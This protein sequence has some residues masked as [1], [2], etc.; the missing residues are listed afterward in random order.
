MQTERLDKK[1]V[2]GWSWY[3]KATAAEGDDVLR[4]LNAT[5]QCRFFSNPLR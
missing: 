5:L 2:H 3:S 4:A 1:G